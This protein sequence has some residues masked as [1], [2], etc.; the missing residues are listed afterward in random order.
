MIFSG[1]YVLTWPRR[2]IYKGML[3]W[4]MSCGMWQKRKA[5]LII[6]NITTCNFLYPENVKLIISK[7]STVN[8]NPIIKS[9]N[10]GQSKMSSS[11]RNSKSSSLSNE[12]YAFIWPN[13][14]TPK[15]FSSP[16]FLSQL[17]MKP[18]WIWPSILIMRFRWN[19][20]LRCVLFGG[21]GRLTFETLKDRLGC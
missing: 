9:H 19:C 10:Y 21:R 2:C 17:S 5:K 12:L 11:W 1:Y 14:F 3:M 4:S 15:A 13:F 6:F 16:L 18:F 8:F 7:S 20:R